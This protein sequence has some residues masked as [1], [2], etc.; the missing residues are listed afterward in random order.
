[1]IKGG[2][3]LNKFNW[4]ANTWRKWTSNVV[5]STGAVDDNQWYSFVLRGFA[6][7]GI[8]QRHN[9]YDVNTPASAITLSGVEF[10]VEVS[11]QIPPIQKLYQK[12]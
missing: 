8:K 1:M 2:D 9:A 3:D 4:L 5:R 11:Q 6:D 10:K 7:Y 12:K